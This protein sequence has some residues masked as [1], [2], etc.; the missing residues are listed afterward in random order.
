ML[1]FGD[2]K[3]LLVYVNYGFRVD[4][5]KFKDM[6]VEVKGVIV[7]VW[8]GGIQIDCVFKVKVVEMVGFVGC[9]IYSDFVDDGF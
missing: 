9:F 1:K 3:G 6:G 7:L 4:F 5:Q 8:Y 2:V